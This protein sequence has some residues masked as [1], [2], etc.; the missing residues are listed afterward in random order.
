MIFLDLVAIDLEDPTPLNEVTG[1]RVN[2]VDGYTNWEAAAKNLAES[3]NNDT[4]DTENFAVRFT[5]GE[6][7]RTNY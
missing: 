5:E 3:I 2:P 7:P 1:K 4:L 6:Y